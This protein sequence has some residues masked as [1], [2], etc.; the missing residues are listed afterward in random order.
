M[1][2]WT[3]KSLAE[4]QDHAEP[5][6]LRRSFGPL[7]LTALGTGSIIGTGIFVLPWAT[8]ERLILGLVAG[9]ALHF[10]YGRRRCGPGRSG[11][12]SPPPHP[13]RR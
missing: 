13:K 11:L 7:D 5:G 2:P 1:S 10:V 4:R 9:L 6:T 3:K 8:W 12:R